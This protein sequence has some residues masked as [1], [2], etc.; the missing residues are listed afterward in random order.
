MLE[1]GAS[2]PIWKCN[3]SSSSRRNRQN[4]ERRCAELHCLPAVFEIPLPS[5]AG[6]EAIIKNGVGAEATLGGIQEVE[7]ASVWPILKD[8]LF[9]AG[10]DGASPAA[11]TIKSEKLFALN[12]PEPSATSFNDCENGDL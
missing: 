11:A 9:Y 1:A 3:G 12:D 2:A 6:K 5:P 7:K 4:L 10:D 8:R